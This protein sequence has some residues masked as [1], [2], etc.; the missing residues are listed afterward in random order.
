MDAYL[1]LGR[2]G[3]VRAVT[4]R[5]IRPE[6]ERIHGARAA[7]IRSE[8]CLRLDLGPGTRPGMLVLGSED[9]HHFSPQQGTDLLA[10][11]GA[12]FERALRRWLA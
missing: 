7:D 5:Q 11:F 12:V 4:L 10:F 3:P 9:P 6:D 8:A 2:G 1:R